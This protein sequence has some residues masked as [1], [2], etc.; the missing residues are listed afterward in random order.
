MYDLEMLVVEV[1]SLAF[2]F[3]GGCFALWQW[4]NSLVY[5]R[6]EIVQMLIEDIRG[7]Q[8][9]SSTMDMIDWNEDF[10][11]NGKFQINR[12]TTRNTLKKLSDDN[13]FQMID[14]TLSAFSYICYLRSV[15]TIRRRDMAFFEYGIRRLVDNP[16]IANYL[17]SLYHWSKS[18]NVEMSFSYIIK[19]C[20]RKK[21]LDR[22]F[23]KYSLHGIYKCFLNIS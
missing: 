16:H 19:Y 15:H 22:S 13:L 11:Y 2:V 4:H 14:Q 18:L 12:N 21:Y 10:V 9:V 5:K 6:A 1:I 17:Y 20:I 7:N 8:S 23:K 3:I